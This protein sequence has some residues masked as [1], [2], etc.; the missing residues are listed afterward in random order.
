MGKKRL[1]SI[2]LAIGALLLLALLPH[3]YPVADRTSGAAA[4]RD[5]MLNAV[6]HYRSLQA[7][8]VHHYYGA[9][10][11]EST[12]EASL[13]RQPGVGAVASLT[14]ADGTRV[15]L[16]TDGTSLTETNL[17]TGETQRTTTG[18][19]RTGALADR[20]RQVLTFSNRD[21]VRP[22]IEPTDLPLGW[23]GTATFPQEW[24]LGIYDASTVQSLGS[25]V[26]LGTATE[27]LAVSAPNG[28]RY[29]VNV[30]PSTGVLLRTEIYEEDR[31]A[32][33]IEATSYQVNGQIDSSIY[34][35]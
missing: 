13:I 27:R 11:S 17:T 7:D 32:Q 22:R 2:I 1:L 5:T 21:T 33:L 3:A 34:T 19:S 31:L 4:L 12:I 30:D 16:V 14:R 26:L 18:S 10:G 15:R 25:Q 23:I 20:I 8:Y 24:V 29:I 9:D 28:R 6:D 35:P